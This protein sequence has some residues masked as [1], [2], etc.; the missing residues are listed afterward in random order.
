MSQVQ[1]LGVQMVP[2][3]LL[4]IRMLSTDFL[5]E[6][7]SLVMVS[8]QLY[9]F[10]IFTA[11]LRS[12]VDSNK[13]TL[14]KEMNYAKWFNDFFIIWP[15]ITLHSISHNFYIMDIWCTENSSPIHYR[16]MEKIAF[17]NWWYIPRHS[18]QRALWT[19]LNGSTISSLFD[20]RLH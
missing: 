5:R 12:Y 2:W 15:Q 11:I 14:Y 6:Y 16:I 10:V 17:K 8:C 7:T 3:F 18:I 20:H 19:M 9:R 1:S 4:W 13:A